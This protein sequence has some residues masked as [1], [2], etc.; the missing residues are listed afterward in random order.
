MNNPM[1]NAGVVAMMGAFMLSSL[2]GGM[3]TGS[4]NDHPSQSKPERPCLTCGKLHQHNNCFC[5]S[6]CCRNYGSGKKDN[7][8]V[9]N[10]QPTA[11]VCN[12]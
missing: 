10:S 8:V 7:R 3:P 11:T 9:A 1:R 4:F 6:E 5:S 2:G 12:S